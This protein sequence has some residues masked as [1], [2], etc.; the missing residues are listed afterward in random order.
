MRQFLRAADY[1][2]QLQRKDTYHQFLGDWGCAV[3]AQYA[4]PVGRDLDNKKAV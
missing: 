2:T 1:S 4:Y 3:D